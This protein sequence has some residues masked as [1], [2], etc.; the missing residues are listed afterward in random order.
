MVE[1]APPLTKKEK[2]KPTISRDQLL[3]ERALPQEAGLEKRIKFLWEGHYRVNYQEKYPPHDIITSYWVII[4]D[5]KVISEKEIP[6]RKC[7]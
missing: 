7:E 2:I 5:G 4:K 6:A 3:V 1:T